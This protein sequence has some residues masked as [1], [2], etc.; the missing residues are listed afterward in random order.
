MEDKKRGRGRP[1][2]VIEKVIFDPSTLDMCRG[3]EI[4]FRDDLLI[5][6]KTNCE[7]DLILSTEGGLM[8]GTNMVFVGGPGSGKST[9]TLDMLASLTQDGQKCLYVSGE[10]DKKGHFKYC[11][12][13]PKFNCVQTLFLQN[14]F[15]N[16]KET[17][18]YAFD[19][20][21]DVIA[22]DSIAEVLEMYREAYNCSLRSAESWFLGLQDKMKNGE[23]Q[24]NY[25]TSFINIQ[26]VTKSGDFTGSNRIKHMT[27]AMAH[28]EV[29]KDGLDRSIYFS[30]NRD[31]DKDYKIFFSIY[32]DGV[33]YAFEQEDKQ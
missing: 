26:Q 1:K 14:H 22:V 7:M 2:K 33:H 31:C 8:P 4:T 25:Y 15:H 16:I 29:A 32:G 12:R 13:I 20:G 17:L 30:K 19:L 11:K 5:P 28:I 3:S 21:Y 18:E 23:N 10:M 27:D 24:G 6:Q 9:I